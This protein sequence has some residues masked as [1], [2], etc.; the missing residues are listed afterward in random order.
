MP[1]KGGEI[2]TDVMKSKIKN[3]VL[4]KVKSYQNQRL[5]K[6]GLGVPKPDAELKKLSG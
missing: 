3:F 5:N 2:S 1:R 4:Q 6:S